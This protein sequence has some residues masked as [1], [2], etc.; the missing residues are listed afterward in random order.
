MVK[1]NISKETVIYP[2]LEI[3][4]GNRTVGSLGTSLPEDR[5]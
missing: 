4:R 3:R 5:S 2:T 1:T